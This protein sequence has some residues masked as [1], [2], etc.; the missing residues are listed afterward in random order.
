MI[1]GS[2]AVKI[3]P[4]FW[5][6]S[7]VVTA[8]ARKLLVRLNASPRTSRLARSRTRKILDNAMSIWKN[9]GPG[10]FDLPA[11]PSVPAVGRAN[12]SLLIQLTQGAMLAHAD[13]GLATRGFART[14]LGL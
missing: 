10:I 2:C 9:P 3:R 8:P 12:A 5:L 14:W 13:P 1:R 6:L 7:A 11:F 4:K